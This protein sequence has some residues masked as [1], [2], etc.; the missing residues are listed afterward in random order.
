[1]YVNSAVYED[2]LLLICQS[3]DGIVGTVL[4]SRGGTICDTREG[5][6]DIFYVLIMGLSVDEDYEAEE[7]SGGIADALKKK[8]SK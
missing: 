5:E 2:K 7:E 3:E 8:Q 1:M 6:E 4:E